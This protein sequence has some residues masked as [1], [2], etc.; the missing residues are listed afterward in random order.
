MAGPAPTLT[1]EH[2]TVFLI[3]INIREI[4]NYAN[5]RDARQLLQL[6]ATIAEQ[7]DI[8]PELVDQDPSN[9]IP[10]RPR[11]KFDRSVYTAKHT[12]AVNIGDQNHR[13]PCFKGNSHVGNIFV[14][15]V[16]LRNTP[17]SFHHN[18]II[19]FVQ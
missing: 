4:G 13:R 1:V 3:N 18:R 7:P 5:N 2:D 17:G 8:S 15:Q 6:F 14:P 9:K 12:A 11:Q 16:N 10:F 19:F